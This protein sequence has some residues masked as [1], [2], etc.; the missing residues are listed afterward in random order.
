V[1]KAL[2][3]AVLDY[4][5]QQGFYNVTLNVWTLN[6]GAQR[7]YEKMGMKPQKVGMEVIL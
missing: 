2:Y 7:F 4:A 1:G 6:P 3:D 5:R